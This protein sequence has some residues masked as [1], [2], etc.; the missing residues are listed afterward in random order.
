MTKRYMTPPFAVELGLMLGCTAELGVLPPSEFVQEAVR[1]PPIYFETAE[2]TAKGVCCV[3]YKKGCLGRCPNSSC[4]LLMHHT[5]VMPTV[6]GEALQC[7]IC[8]TEA[9]LDAELE[10][11]GQELPYWHEAE[12]GAPAGRRKKR[13]YP[14]VEQAPFPSPRWPPQE[15]AQTH[16][17][18]TIKD[19]YL[20]YRWRASS[21]DPRERKHDA[22][23]ERFAAEFVAI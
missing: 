1:P 5:C 10:E 21:L 16:G 7:P 9:R 19:W 4:G 23:L 22:G 2:P 18:E 17:Y 11:T 12:V 6:Q 14:E 8:R 20:G 13:T 15:E 3:C